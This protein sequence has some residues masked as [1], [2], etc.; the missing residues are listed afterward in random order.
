MNLTNIASGIGSLEG[1]ATK[2]DLQ[3]VKEYLQQLT[4]ELRYELSH[5]DESNMTQEIVNAIQ[6]GS[7]TRQAGTAGWQR[8]IAG[9]KLE[10]SATAES[11]LLRL[12]SGNLSI[13]TA[14]IYLGDLIARIINSAVSMTIEQQY[15]VGAIY[16]FDGEEDPSD[17]LGIGTWE[18]ITPAGFTGYKTYK[19]INDIE[20]EELEYGYE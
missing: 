7:N 12:Y 3:Q 17:I 20:S 8:S 1:Q 6:A 16:S 2:K 19:R 15:P 13:N 11:I 9:L 5:I 14:S 18:D 4:D 10:G